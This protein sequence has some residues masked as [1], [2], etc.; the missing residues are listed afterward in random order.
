MPALRVRTLVTGLDHPWDVK[1][2]GHGRL[3]YTQRERATVS[4]W[5]H[6]HHHRVKFPSRQVWVKGRAGLMSLEVDPGFARNGRFYTCQSGYVHGGG[7][8]IHVLAWHLDK[9]ATRA[10][11][12]RELLGGIPADPRARHSGCRLL[13]ARDG[14]LLVGTGDAYVGTNAE[15]LTSLGG[16]TLRLNRSPGSR[17]TRTRSCTP[18]TATSA[19][20]RPTD[21][22]TSRAWRSAGT[23]PCGRWSRAPS[24]TTR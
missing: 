16:K 11:K 2:I 3:L 15:D 5:Q 8:Q 1:P 20:C 4:V 18:A 21:T 13:I 17:G 23:V 22:A 14:S 7:H 10:R 6:G 9:H 12:V 19:T 24:A